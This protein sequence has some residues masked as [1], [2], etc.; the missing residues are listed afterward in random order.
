MKGNERLETAQHELDRVIAEALAGPGVPRIEQDVDLA[1][2]AASLTEADRAALDR[3]GGPAELVGRLFESSKT[4]EAQGPPGGETTQPPCGEVS[5]LLG[6]TST[7]DTLP[8]AAVGP[9]AGFDGLVR[10]YDACK[11]TARVSWRSQYYKRKEIGRGGQ[12]VVYLIECQDEFSGTRALKVFS[13]EPYGDLANYH[14]DMQRMISVAA[15]VHRNRHD[16]LIEVERFACH[17]GIYLMVMRLIDGYD[18]R[19]LL[20][21]AMLEQLRGSVT[22]S[23]WADLMKVVIAPPIDGRWGLTPGI[24]VNIIEKCLRGVS[25]LHG[26]GIIHGDIKQANIMLDCFGSIRLI[27][28]GS[29]FEIAAPPRQHSCTPR[30]AAPEVLERREWSPQSD[31]ASLGYVL[32]ELLCGG[33]LFDD[34]HQHSDSTRSMHPATDGQ[35]LEA[36][37]RLPEQLPTLLPEDAQRSSRLVRLCQRLIDPDPRERFASAEEAVAGSDGTNE[38]KQELVRANLAVLWVQDIMNWLADVKR[39]SGAYNEVSGD[40]APNSPARKAQKRLEGSR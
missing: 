2:A 16:N 27:D 25:A 24:A 28:I 36:K 38:F 37:Y 32:I 35:L 12:G 26:K 34:L 18:L 30:Y 20:Q 29:S 9:A 33:R 39:A 1:T 4:K 13:P 40:D 23:R 3:L 10:A 6:S 31:L 7:L 14:E 11:R 22:A 5:T 21:P 19:C 15:I 17:D 8:T